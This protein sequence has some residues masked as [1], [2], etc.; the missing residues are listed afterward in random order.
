[1]P[2]PF[3]A[4]AQP[5]KGLRP[6]GRRNESIVRCRLSSLAQASFGQSDM[7]QQSK[8][9]QEEDNM[10]PLDRVFISTWAFHT[11]ARAIRDRA[12]YS[13]H[14]FFIRTELVG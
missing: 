1:M 13:S 7:H 5:E 10:L 6:K 9:D 11:S 3:L 14:T 12:C 2:K 4:S 8:T